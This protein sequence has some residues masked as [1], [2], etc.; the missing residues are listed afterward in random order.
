MAWGDHQL[1]VLPTDD[2]NLRVAMKSGAKTSSKKLQRTRSSSLPRIRRNT[3][4]A[5]A[6]DV[7]WDAASP[8]TSISLDETETSSSS[9][10]SSTL[11]EHHALDDATQ[12][13]S[14]T[15]YKEREMQLLSQLRGL[16]QE[17][18]H[19]QKN[20]SQK[21]KAKAVQNQ[22][23]SI[24]TANN[25]NNNN[26]QQLHKKKNKNRRALFKREKSFV[27]HK[28]SYPMELLE[29]LQR[30]TN[31]SQHHIRSCIT[32]P[33]RQHRPKKTVRFATNSYNDKV[34]GLVK[35]IPRTN[36]LLQKILFWSDDELDALF[37][38]DTSIASTVERDFVRALR[39]HYDGIALQ[40]TSSQGMD[41]CCETLA[42]H[43]EARG[44]ESHAFPHIRPFCLRHRQAVLQAQTD[45]R[46]AGLVLFNDM[47]LEYIRS[48]SIKLSKPKREFAQKLAQAD[49]RDAKQ[50]DAATTN[51][52]RKHTTRR[53]KALQKSQSWSSSV[54]KKNTKKADSSAHITEHL[55]RGKLRKAQ[56]W[57]SKDRQQHLV[58]TPKR[59]MK[60]TA[61]G[62][63]S[64]E[65]RLEDIFPAFHD[66]WKSM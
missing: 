41:L 53:R 42:H 13:S 2:N 6:G 23:V 51:K 46:T 33:E 65:E 50:P 54:P 45:L 30:Q 20:V 31:S 49:Q 47:A 10:S 39:T 1:V 9:S 52:P 34:W 28:S 16:H 37:G 43:P 56:S 64:K 18:S 29:L 15:E 27:F 25:N 40:A 17:L 19:V 60:G 11:E 38:Q 3:T 59:K 4:D 44:L 66:S 26:Q 35:T 58:S 57:S 7:E 36:R 22:Q 61:S 5:D 48:E 55:G 62:G 14:L 63:A 32:A 12:H 21:S 8:D 24:Q